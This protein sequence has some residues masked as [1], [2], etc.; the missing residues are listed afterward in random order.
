MNVFHCGQCDHLVFFESTE[1]LHCGHSLAYLPDVGAIAALEHDQSGLWRAVGVEGSEG[2]YR[3]CT[4]YSDTGVCNWAVAE[5]DPHALCISCRLTRV[6]PDLNVPEQRARWHLLELA[7]RR[8]VYT[9]VGLRLPLTSRD[10]DPVDGVAFDFLA[11]AWTGSEPVLTG[12]ADGVIT[13]N[14]AEADE[15]ERARQK[16]RLHEPYRTLLGHLRHESGH[17]YWDRLIA[18]SDRLQLFRDAFG[19]ERQDYAESIRRHYEG[20]VSTGWSQ[21]FVSQYAG[22]HPWEDWAETWAHYLH[23]TDTLQ[24]A[25]ACGL[26]IRPRRTHE[27][28]LQEVPVHAGSV[29]ASF[30]Q[31]IESWFPVTYILNNLNRGL[32]L[33]DGYPFVLTDV[34][35]GKLRFVHDTIASA[36]R[37]QRWGR[38]SQPSHTARQ[39]DQVKA[40]ARSW[41]PYLLHAR[42]VCSTMPCTLSNQAR[43]S[44][45]VGA[46][47]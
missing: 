12:H 43:S 28:V 2:G 3:L 1:C 42:S 31:L 29:E 40:L 41:S 5:S 33:P 4:H 39:I 25:A 9:L 22:A 19:D 24:T 36:T 10:D 34:S 35:I 16:T 8:L 46:N 11:D 27:P 17:Y 6:I 44:S 23:L 32:G 38:K 30:D 13:V 7:K 47:S 45:C 20:P 15:A 26:S 37:F 14:I 21:A 18:R